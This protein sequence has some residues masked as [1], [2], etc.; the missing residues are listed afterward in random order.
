ME[1]IYQMS[2]KALRKIV[3]Y[4]SLSFKPERLNWT[5][6]NPDE[7]SDYIYKLL[8]S[9]KPCMVAR[10]GSTELLAVCNFLGVMS[11]QHSWWKFI[12]GKQF[13]WWWNEKSILQLQNN[14][15]FFPLKKD[16]IA[17]FCGLML[18]CSREVDLL[19]N[20]LSN[21]Y[22]LR[23]YL[24]NVAKCGL[25]S[26]EPYWSS[27]PWSRALAGKK[28]LVVHPFAETILSQYQQREH[29]FENSDVLP[30]FDLKVIPAVQSLGGNSEFRTWFDALR[31][32]E[33]EM[34]ATD[35]DIALIGCGAYGFP[36]A[37]HAKR[38]G[39]KAIH[40]GGA[41]QLLF[42]IKGKRWENENY[43][44]GY[45][46]TKLFNSFWVHPSRKETPA[47]S[48]LVEGGCYW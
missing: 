40:L 33:D 48:N 47:V 37:A 34:D 2:L 29:L 19:G 22:Y 3:G 38:M 1:N 12:T 41:L 16:Y 28:V 25:L 18:H 10:Y 39:K 45:D 31:W 24:K 35:Y 30:E 6:H 43:C 36:L 8:N 23:D 17:E 44:E 32:M 4:T 14:S 7:V 13:Q 27:R 15:G 42:G 11:R 5:L 20:W 21:E 26:L 9:D 46:Y